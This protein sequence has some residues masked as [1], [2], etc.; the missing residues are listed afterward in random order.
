MSNQNCGSCNYSDVGSTPWNWHCRLHDKTISSSDR[1]MSWEGTPSNYSQWEC[2]RCGKTG[3]N[4][5][6]RSEL[7][8]PEGR[9]YF[10]CHS[11]FFKR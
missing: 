3:N 6:D 8:S 4:E 5:A 1:C 9:K 2:D 10:L 7:T 11:C